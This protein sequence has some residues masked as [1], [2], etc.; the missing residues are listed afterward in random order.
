[1]KFIFLMLLF[2]NLSYAQDEVI[3][4]IVFSNTKKMNV[5]FL[6][7]IIKTKE[8]QSLDSTQIMSDIQVLNRLNGIS[9]AEFDIQLIENNKYEV[10]YTVTENHSLIPILS[11]W[12]TNE[13]GAYRIGLYEY[14]FLGKNNTLGGFY[15]YNNYNS[16][17]LNF[18]S[19]Q[20]FSS[21]YGF[22]FNTQK[23]VSKEPV[24]FD[25]TSANYIYSNTAA[26][27][28]GV[29]QY[30]AK[31]Q[32]KLGITLFNEKYKYIEGAMNTSIPQ[33]LNL[34]KKLIKAAYTY[35]NLNYDYYI[36]SGFKN[37]FFFQYVISENNFQ[38]K[39]LIGWNDFLYYKRIGNRGNWASRLRLGLAS[40]NE[41]PFSP[42]SVDNNLNIRGVGNIIDRGTGTIVLNTEFRKTLFEKNWFV[43]QGN[44]FVDSGTWRNPGGDFSDFG[45][46]KNFRVYSGLGI[47]FIHK[48]IF[49]AVF[50]LDYG[51]GITKNASQGVV[52][53]I[54]QYF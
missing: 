25:N 37:N 7:K 45:N 36:V 32:F 5:D 31:N 29:Y 47:R 17:G 6:K 10:N 38:E 15:Q 35:D 28:V 34:N 22:E 19:P 11:V 41:S 3:G 2:L 9:K 24:F 16:F 49:N 42:F 21:K 33:N 48:T 40:N 20:F 12:T 51:Y 53:G 14:N 30:N 13:I 27:T 44:A 26:E 54:G 4:K 39:F 23:L 46:S 8:G 18:S 52:F 50:R 43:L 1:M